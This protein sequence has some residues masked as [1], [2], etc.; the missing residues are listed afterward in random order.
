MTIS[1]QAWAGWVAIGT[2]ED[3]TD[4]FNDPE[5][6]RRE[7]FRVKVWELQNFKTPIKGNRSTRLR[8]EYDCRNERFRLL[9]FTAHSGERA[10]GEITFTQST[11][12]PWI[13]IPPQSV[14]E[15]SSKAV[16]K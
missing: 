3:D 16:C 14:V 13:D 12:G 5:T 4:F 7:G 10:S 2:S 11:E 9:S 1:C 6:I 8:V 15:T